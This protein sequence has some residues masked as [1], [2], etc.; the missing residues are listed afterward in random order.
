MHR[1]RMS[2]KREKSNS[3]YQINRC[4]YL[5]IAPRVSLFENMVKT[6]FRKKSYVT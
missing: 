6:P 2:E 1:K 3:K 4:V 5:G